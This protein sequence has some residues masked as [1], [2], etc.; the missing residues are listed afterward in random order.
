MGYGAVQEINLERLMKFNT[1]VNSFLLLNV[2]IV[3]NQMSSISFP[4]G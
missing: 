2:D 4:I 1:G 3:C